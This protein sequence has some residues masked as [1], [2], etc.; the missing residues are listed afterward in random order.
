[1]IRPKPMDS[2]CRRASHP[3][4]LQRQWADSTNTHELP[5]TSLNLCVELIA[6]REELELFCR[7]HGELLKGRVIVYKHM[8][9]WDI[10]L[11]ETLQVTEAAKE[12]LDADV[13]DEVT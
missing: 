9:H 5:N 4:R 2:E 3:L 1:M 11:H 8:E 10:G 12:E 7:K 6:R 13:E